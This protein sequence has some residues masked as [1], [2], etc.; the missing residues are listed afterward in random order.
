MS[1]HETKDLE[2]AC[3]AT[4]GWSVERIA[5]ARPIDLQFALE[6]HK[7]QV[8]E[9][10]TDV[11]PANIE[12]EQQVTE[13]IPRMLTYNRRPQQQPLVTP[14]L[15][16]PMISSSSAAVATSYT[17][18]NNKT[19][20]FGEQYIRKQT[21]RLVQLKENIASKEKVIATADTEKLGLEERLLLDLALSLDKRRYSRLSAQ[22]QKSQAKMV[23]SVTRKRSMLNMLELQ[24]QQLDAVADECSNDPPEI[25]GDDETQQERMFQEK[26][27]E[28][29][30]QIMT[31]ESYIQLNLC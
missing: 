19:S 9:E 13:G 6:A 10:E 26:M 8:E 28:L 24:Q 16:T 20:I 4:L 15:V 21:A 3:L 31:L 18:N 1:L 25:I 17:V 14:S 23:A 11:V 27:A 22:F 2:A 12:N 29:R 30:T 5:R 7:K